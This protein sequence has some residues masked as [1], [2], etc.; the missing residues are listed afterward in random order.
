MTGFEDWMDDVIEAEHEQG[1]H[2][3]PTGGEQKMTAKQTT[4][5]DN[6][7]DFLKRIKNVNWKEVEQLYQGVKA[8]FEEGKAGYQS[9]CSICNEKG[10]PCPQHSKYDAGSELKAFVTKLFSDAHSEKPVDVSYTIDDIANTALNLSVDEKQRV[11]HARIAANAYTIL[12]KMPKEGYAQTRSFI[13]TFAKYHAD[14][15]VGKE[16]GE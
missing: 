9:T 13:E 3:Q 10:K 2:C 14:R 16:K 12:D 5:N 11:H 1:L 4:K 8:L 7:D 6:S 15:A